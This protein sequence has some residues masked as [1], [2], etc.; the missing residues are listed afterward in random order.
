MA[1]YLGDTIEKFTPGGV[2]SVFANTGLNGPIGLAIDKAG[3]VYVANYL[4]D[5]IEKF[6]PGGV[7]SVFANTGL[8]GPHGLAFDR[9]GSIRF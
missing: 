1:N 3:N 4:G 7:G 8:N 9:A 6:N 5:T 2:G